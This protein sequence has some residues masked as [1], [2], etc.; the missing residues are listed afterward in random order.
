M[1]EFFGFHGLTIQLSSAS[2]DLVKEL[3]RDFAYFRIPP[4]EQRSDVR[5]ELNLNPP[6]YANLPPA[7]ALFSTPRN[8]CFKN[9]SITYVDYFGEALAVR[10]DRSCSVFGT[11]RDLVREIAYLFILSTAGQHFDRKGLHRVHALGISYRQRGILLLLPA[12]GGKSTMALKLLNNPGFLLLGEDTPLIDRQG[13]ILPFPLPLGIQPGLDYRIPQKHLR[14]VNRMEFDP[15]TLIDIE[16]FNNRIGEAVEPF[17]LLVGERNLGEI[18]EIT[19]LPLHKAFKAL[20]KYM[21]VGLGI[22]QGLEF[23]LERS[24]LEL[25]TKGGVVFS[26]LYNCLR[27][28]G[29]SKTFKFKLGRDKEKNCHTLIEFVRRTSKKINDDTLFMR[30]HN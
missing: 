20:L 2:A 6:P 24:A 18:S 12:G 11:D 21:V 5:V 26:R 23:L 15:K 29:R 8:I 3:R 16:Y 22:Y 9:G 17:L 1:K 4:V 7:R 13:R 27:L 25:A 10:A 19:P 30:K 14:T 28:L